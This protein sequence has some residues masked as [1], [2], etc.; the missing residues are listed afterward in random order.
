[1]SSW[2]L[3]YLFPTKK[4]TFPP[5]QHRHSQEISTAP[6]LPPR[7]QTPSCADRCH[8]SVLSAQEA[9]SEAHVTL[10]VLLF[11][12]LRSEAACQPLLRFCDV[13]T[14][15]AHDQLCRGRHLKLG[16]SG[17]ST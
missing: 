1:M 13:D 4:T 17:A 12:P 7:P 11:C 5:G 16:F 15:E 9:S 2:I 6:S 14:S 8:I 3:C 10:V